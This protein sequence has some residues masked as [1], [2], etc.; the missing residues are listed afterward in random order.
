MAAVYG[1]ILTAWSVAGVV[2]PQIVA[3]LKDRVPERASTLSFA[4]G[5]GFLGLGFLLSL[6]LSDKPAAKKA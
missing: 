2:G 5:A 3:V 4:V 6:L 1:A